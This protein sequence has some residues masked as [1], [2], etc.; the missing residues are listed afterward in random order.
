MHPEF[1]RISKNIHIHV[2]HIKMLFAFRTKAMKHEVI[3]DTKTIWVKWMTTYRDKTSTTI[4]IQ[5][6]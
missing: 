1:I 3:I 6:K 2:N 5:A 4:L